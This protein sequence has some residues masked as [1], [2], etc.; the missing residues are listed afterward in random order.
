[1]ASEIMLEVEGVSRHF[2]GVYAV[3]DLSFKVENGEIFGVIGPNGAGKTT[4]LN[5]ISGITRLNAG[6][7]TFRKERIDGLAIRKVASKGIA[8]TFQL[9]ETFRSFRV[10]DY[11]LLGRSSWRPT[12][13][14]M[15]GA[16][17]PAMRRSDKV[18]MGVASELIERHG[19][20]E[21][22]DKP[23]RELAYGHQ[24]IVD[25]VR[26][27]AAEPQLLLLD[28]PTS[29]SSL[30]ERRYLRSLITKL[31]DE[32]ITVVVVD[33]DVSFIS[34]TCSRVFAMA[35]GQSIMLGTPEE[36]LADRRVVESYLGVQ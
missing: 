11:V 4:L 7:V 13:L 14:L 8:R 24:K 21:Y 30:E 16:A 29:G 1:V 20:Q 2:G 28:E 36:V 34:D 10:I 9:A 26:A 18:Q 5:C 27:L 3:E 32:G 25:I 35:S 17:M 15:C 6:T 23:I 12:S 33:H 31:R 19:L 22:R